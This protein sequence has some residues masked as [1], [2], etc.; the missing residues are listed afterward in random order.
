[1]ENAQRYAGDV[2]SKKIEIRCAVIVINRFIKIIYVHVFNSIKTIFLILA[3]YQ[4]YVNTVYTKICAILILSSVC[5][6]RMY[7]MKN[8]LL[9]K[10][11]SVVLCAAVMSSLSLSSAALSNKAGAAGAEGYVIGDFPDSDYLLNGY[12]YQL[13]GLTQN[14]NKLPFNSGRQQFD[15]MHEA[16]CEILGEKLKLIADGTIS[17]TVIEIS[18]KEISRRSGKSFSIHQVDIDL[19]LNILLYDYPYELYWFDKD[20]GITAEGL[21]NI[22]F[23]FAVSSDYSMTGNTNTFVTDTNKISAAARAVENAKAIVGS[24]DKNSSDYEAMR[25]FKDQI[26]SLVSYDTNSITN[27][28]YGDP[29]QLINVFDG[30]ASTNVVCE[31]YSKAFKYLCDLYNFHS[32]IKCNMIQGTLSYNGGN[33]PHMWNFVSINGSN[34]LVDITNSEENAVGCDGE[35]F[36]AYAPLANQPMYTNGMYAGADISVDGNIVKY[37]YGVSTLNVFDKNE[38]KISEKPLVL[39][40]VLWEN[41]DGSLLEKDTNV[42][43]GEIPYYNGAEPTPPRD[44]TFDGWTPDSTVPISS[45]DDI[46]KYTAKY[47]GVTITHNVTFMFGNKVLKKME[48]ADE[49]TIGLI[50]V[51]DDNYKF[52]GWYIDPGFKTPYDVNSKIKSDI[53]LY[54]KMT[55]HAVWQDSNGQVLY[56]SDVPYGSTPEF[57][58]SLPQKESD[59]EYQYTFSKWTPST[60]NANVNVTYTPVFES[61]ERY[62]S[63]MWKNA[64]GSVLTVTKCKYGDTPQYTGDTPGLKSE[65]EMKYVFL[66][67]TPQ[68]TKIESD[69]VYTAEYKEVIKVLVYGDVDGDGYVDSADALSILRSSVGLTVFSEDELICADVDVNNS[70][71]SG[72]ALAV[73]RYSVGIFQDGTLIGKNV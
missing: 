50:D 19:I 38:L 57:K 46:V 60:T 9:I 4:L 23:S 18:G 10:S 55:Y 5:N 25:Y 45:N 24:V 33:E 7:A 6:E 56:E 68:I 31:G 13:S 65:G 67:W 37:S 59:K 3:N 15:S 49:D 41:S 73:L 22:T 16:I 44:G 30:D 40:T 52:N 70:V 11:A 47:Y 61:K 14:N 39:H 71:D 36:F 8:T 34:Y 42:A 2:L 21:N 48:F 17:D 29:W 62:Y 64:D 66:G 20:V 43:D 35:L 26:C 27:N 63:V 51:K 54:A 32:N 53:T 58:G 72:D 12:I 69:V 28:N 1:M